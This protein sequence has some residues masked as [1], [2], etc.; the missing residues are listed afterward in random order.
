MM[1]AFDENIRETILNTRFSVWENFLRDLERTAEPDHTLV[2]FPNSSTYIFS[3]G[4]TTF[5][6]MDPCF[7][8]VRYDE[9][10]L[11]RIAELIARKIRFI[12][13]THLHGDH[14]QGELVRALR[15]SPVHWIIS[16]RFREAFV[17]AFGIAPDRITALADGGE[18]RDRKSVV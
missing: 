15:E 11:R 8:I 13:I 1:N 17:S 5:W 3:T 6:M 4:G 18:T 7:N 2:R 12:V 16:E 14:C 9:G 10:E